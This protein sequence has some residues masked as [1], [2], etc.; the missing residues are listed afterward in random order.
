MSVTPAPARS[1]RFLG[2]VRRAVLQDF[3]PELL[4]CEKVAVLQAAGYKRSEI[5]RMLDAATPAALKAAELRV[6]V[7]AERLEAE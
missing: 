4:L 1:S 6:K 5:A 2:H 7:A 3:E